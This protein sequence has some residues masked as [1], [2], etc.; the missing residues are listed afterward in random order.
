MFALL[1]FWLCTLHG[2]RQTRRT[3]KF[4]LPKFLIVFPMWLAALTMEITQE[5]NEVRDPTFSFQINT[6]H[7]KRFQV[8]FFC[9][10]FIY[11]AYI[12]FLVAK[13]FTELRSMQFIQ[14]RLKFITSFMGIIITLCISIVYTKFGFGVL[15]D[16]FISRFYTSYDSV[17]QFLSF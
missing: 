6:A 17:T 8:L 2:L 3:W 5:F 13:A 14:T 9:L 1:A 4:Y 15:E 11:T 7:Y 16:N 10:L 12:V